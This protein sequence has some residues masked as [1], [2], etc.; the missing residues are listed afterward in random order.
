[1]GLGPGCGGVGSEVQGYV[2]PLATVRGPSWT[3]GKKGRKVAETAS[4]GVSVGE[5]C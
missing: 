2:Y 5:G 3:A 1:M 4:V